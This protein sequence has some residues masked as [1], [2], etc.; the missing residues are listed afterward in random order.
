VTEALRVAVT[1]EQC[2]HRI[3]GGVGRSTV[4]TS[5][6]LA[7]RADLRL[8][9]VAAAHRARPGPSLAPP[10]PVV[11]HRLP[12]RA[13]YE[14]WHRLGWPSVG[15]VTGPVDVIWA[16]AMAIPPAEAPLVATVHDLAFL[17]H[18]TWS[19][20]RGLSFFRRSWAATV[21][22][23][24]MVVAPSHTTADDCVRHGLEAERVVVVPWG[25]EQVESTPDE[26]GAARRDLGLPDRFVL[27]VGT[28]EPRKNLTG[29]VAAMAEVDLPLVVVGPAGWL[30]EPDA[31]LGPLGD[32]VR[33]L[34]ELS[35]ERLRAVY[36]AATVVAFPSLAEG[37]GLPVLEAMVQATPVVTSAGTA[38]ADVAGDAAE[39]VDPRDPTA[40]AG[41]ISELA[42]EGER[43]R[44]L[45]AAGRRR[46]AAFT[47]QATAEGYRGAFVAAAGGF[48]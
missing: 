28:A 12:R 34:G 5:R 33:T 26:V 17:D 43:R 22:R 31:V 10:I 19:T 46:A 44:L 23:A 30:V 7:G 25:V 29:L 35:D 4:A 38:T 14:S 11:H 18:P 32:R 1:L 36:A 21:E 2:W 40:L 6:A 15:A 24:S 39:L 42:A 41:A 20:R 37:F 45:R 8:V 16:S 27:W 48:R 47:W 13:L 3:P 9:G